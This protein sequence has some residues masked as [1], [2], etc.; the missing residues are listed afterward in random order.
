VHHDLFV[1]LYNIFS[2]LRG[3]RLRQPRKQSIRLHA[4]YED[5]DVSVD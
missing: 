3:E 2:L 1:W 5:F 4:S